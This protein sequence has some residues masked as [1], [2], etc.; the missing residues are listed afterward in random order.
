MTLGAFAGVHQAPAILHRHRCRH[1]DE[2]VFALLHHTQGHG[3]M[4]FPRRRD[5]DSV[6]VVARH[7]LLPNVLGA[8]VNGGAFAG[9]HFAGGGGPL[10]PLLAPIANRDHFGEFNA[11]AAL[12]MGHAPIQADD[13]HAHFFQRLGGEMVHRLMAG[14]A[15]TSQADVGRWSSGGGWRSRRGATGEGC[16]HAGQSGR[17]EKIAAGKI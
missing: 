10:R 8:A 15:R 7:H 2:R 13:G 5:I 17:F 4:P 12:N 6:N 9:F 1:F 16:T 3:H 11:K 14:G